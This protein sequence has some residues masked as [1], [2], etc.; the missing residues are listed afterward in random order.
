MPR[1]KS[2]IM[3]VGFG[4]FVALVLIASRKFGAFSEIS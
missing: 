3:F 4:L 1:G 2:I